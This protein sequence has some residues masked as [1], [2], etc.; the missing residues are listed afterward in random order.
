L[1]N[2]IRIVGSFFGDHVVGA[3]KHIMK[4]LN[5]VW[6]ETLQDLKIY[7]QDFRIQFQVYDWDKR[8]KD[9]FLG[10]SQLLDLKKDLK[11]EKKR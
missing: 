9:D 6:N 5:P 11:L 10:E 2:Q 4:T 3:T 7:K 1:E 8:G